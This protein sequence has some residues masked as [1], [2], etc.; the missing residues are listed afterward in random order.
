MQDIIQII[1][2]N[3]E[4]AFSGI[5]VTIFTIIIGFLFKSK[6]EDKVSNNIYLNNKVET[7]K[8]KI[9]INNNFEND[10]MNSNL[11]KDL[12]HKPITQIGDTVEAT[13]KFVT[14]PFKFLGM[15]SDELEK[16]YKKFISDSINKI[17]KEKIVQPSP[18]IASKLLDNVKYSFNTDNELLTKMFSDLLSSSMDKDL[19]E[20]I[21]PSYIDN[22]SN[23][24][25]VDACICKLLME[26]GAIHKSTFSFSEK[27]NLFKS[28]TTN[29]EM[30]VFMGMSSIY[31]ICYKNYTGS[32]SEISNEE[33]GLSISFLKSIGVISVDKE[34]FSSSKEYMKNINTMLNRYYKYNFPHKSKF[35]EYIYCNYEKEEIDFNYDLHKAFSFVTNELSATNDNKFCEY[36][37][38]LDIDYENIEVKRITITLTDY[39]YGFLKNCIKDCITVDSP[40]YHNVV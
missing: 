21:H 40:D 6:K 34:I 25:Y 22:L 5:G 7:D 15:T 14:L 28:S 39:G 19:K 1:I 16:K 20:Q 24:N 35:F 23:M 18:L 38:K 31:T 27:L 33:F 32:I 17:P 37:T 29:K 12:L 9:V 30:A 8:D 3:K 2:N 10:S 4:W 26:N 11:Y 36:E 13:M